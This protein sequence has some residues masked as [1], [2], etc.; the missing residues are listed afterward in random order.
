[1]KLKRVIFD[2][3]AAVD[4]AIAL[5]VLVSHPN[6]ELRAITISCTGETRGEP[7]ARNFSRICQMMGQK[8]IPIAYSSSASFSKEQNPFP[9]WLRNH[10]DNLLKF[11]EVPDFHDVSVSDSAIDLMRTVFENSEK[12]KITIVATGPLTN[13]ADLIKQYPALL[14]KI[15]NIVIMGGAI[16][17]CGNVPLLNPGSP[18]V[19]AEL[20]IYADIKAANI[21]FSSGIPITLVPLDVTCQ[22]PLTKEFYEEMSQQITP[23]LKFIFHLL[24]GR[25]DT[26]DGLR[27]DG[28]FFSTF[29]LWDPLAAI[30]AAEPTIAKYEAVALSVDS[31]SG[32]ILA[33]QASPDELPA[34]LFAKEIDQPEKVLSLLIDTVR[35][36]ETAEDHKI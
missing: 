29:H 26:E 31:D 6:I 36:Y 23:A 35:A 34:A 28:T 15:E 16:H 27:G 20:N 2:N 25:K 30:I 7:G 13:I 21:V 9:E 8:N 10:V 4:D 11:T 19:D 32:K 3:D 17:V 14:N 18:F 33:K 1:M 24:K 5:V 12:E 22:V